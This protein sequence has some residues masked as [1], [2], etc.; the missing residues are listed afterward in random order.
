[1]LIKA[2]LDVLLINV[3]LILAY[4]FR[5]KIL[6]FISPGSIPLLE[7]YLNVLVFITVL[8]L[9]VFKLTGLYEEK[10][11]PALI[12]ELAALFL[13]VSLAT[14]LLLGLLFLY[15]ELW[16]SRLVVVNAWW[17][18]LVLLGLMRTSVFGWK[19]FLR[20]RGWSVKNTLILGS[21][22]NGR[23]LAEKIRQNKGLG[24]RLVEM[25]DDDQLKLDRIRTIIEREKV[26]EIIFASSQIPAAMILD[27]ITD[28][29]RFWG[30]I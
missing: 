16:F 19:K 9:A 6:L 12:D 14:L 10:K 17:I 11:F 8:W 21:G 15:R 22:E 18:N 13:S 26:T 30:G 27:I 1:M 25:L 7:Q 4:F 2:V 24:Y 20:S 29:E 3:S 23:A 5:F 28:C